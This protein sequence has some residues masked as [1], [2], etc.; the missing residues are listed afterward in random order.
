L[1]VVYNNYTYNIE[2][3]I[4]L[5]IDTLAKYSMVQFFKKLNSNNK[6]YIACTLFFLLICVFN[7]CIVVNADDTVESELPSDDEM[8]GINKIVKDTEVMKMIQNQADAHERSLKELHH[9]IDDQLQT[10]HDHFEIVVEK[11]RNKEHEILTQVEKLE[12]R[13]LGKVN[14]VGADAAKGTG[15][16]WPFILL[17]LFLGGIISVTVKRM[18]DIEKKDEWYSRSPTASAWR[19]KERYD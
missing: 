5:I 14:K 18:K 3:V 10:I 2:I 15:W 8:E 4:V 17:L 13:L 12:K 6:I 7:I 9:N 11:M 19:R 1:K 16:F